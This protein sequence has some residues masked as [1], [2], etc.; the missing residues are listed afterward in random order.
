MRCIFPSPFWVDSQSMAGAQIADLVAHI[1]MDS[2]MPESLLP[3]KPQI[4]IGRTPVDHPR[5]VAQDL[6]RIAERRSR[7][8]RSRKVNGPRSRVRSSTCGVTLR[9]ETGGRRRRTA[10]LR[11]P[12]SATPSPSSRRTA[13]YTSPRD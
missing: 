11:A 9:A 12:G 8:W 3:F 2:M 13:S 10:Q 6:L 1:L 7:R 5:K 4:A